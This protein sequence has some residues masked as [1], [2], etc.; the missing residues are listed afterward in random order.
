MD[1]TGSAWLPAPSSTTAGGVD[2]L[3]NF[4]LWSSVVLF[5]I[6]VAGIV[7]FAM[8]YR[9][10]GKAGLTDSKDHNIILEITWTAIPTVMILI[11]FFWGF[12]DFVKGHVAPANAIE[13]KATGQ[14]W[15]WS[16]DYPEGATAVNELVVPVNKPVKLLMSSKDVIHS[17]FVP[18]FRV[19]MDLL[20]NRYTSTWFEATYEGEF[21]LYCAEFCGKGHSEMIGK[22]RVVSDSAYQAW[23]EAS[24]V[25]GEGLSLEEYGA[26]LY[27]AKACITCHS[28]DGSVITG[29]SFLG[30]YGTM[31][32]LQDGS[33]VLFDE[34]YARESIL[35]P[36]A[37]VV[38]GYQPVM[39]TFQGILKDRQIDALIAF[40]KSI[41]EK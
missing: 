1:T 13:I 20:P 40:I 11:V 21:Q 4:I 37:K 3:F 7:V 38:E 25:L 35:N 16:F 34:N 32:T 31:I 9:R 8:R 33:T 23:I 29:P 12:K 19:K 27:K 2:D 26:Q 17:F 18:N 36:K 39:P 10:R 24:T 28:L 14:K 41:N 15:F 30:L 6:V 5:G 22:V